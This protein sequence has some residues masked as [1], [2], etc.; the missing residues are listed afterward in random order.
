MSAE[1]ENEL[2]SLKSRLWKLRLDRN[3]P[4]STFN[5]RK[6]KIPVGSAEVAALLSKYSGNVVAS[7]WKFLLDCYGN[8]EIDEGIS[9]CDDVSC[10][11]KR[12]S[13]LPNGEVGDTEDLHDGNSAPRTCRAHYLL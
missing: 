13:P 2:I 4:E 6:D 1:E 8:E 11:L 9:G 5:K 3:N 7:H 12:N 10:P